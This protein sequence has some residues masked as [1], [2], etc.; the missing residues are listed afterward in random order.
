MDTITVGNWF[1]IPTDLSETKIHWYFNLTKP[2]YDLCVISSTIK[3]S[4]VKNRFCWRQKLRAV[5]SW[6]SIWALICV[7]NE[8]SIHELIA[9][10]NDNSITIPTE[11]MIPPIRDW[12]S[13]LTLMSSVDY[14]RFQAAKILWLFIFQQN[15]TQQLNNHI[16]QTQQMESLSAHVQFKRDI[17]FSFIFIFICRQ[18]RVIHR[19]FFGTLSKAAC[20]AP[21][22]WDWI[23]AFAVKR[24]N[25]RRKVLFSII[26]PAIWR[27]VEF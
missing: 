3:E 16:I 22:W 13:D 23:S 17:S 6:S 4:K 11:W 27:W 12:I 15:F 7:R 8:I 14:R 1:R 25:K 24:R 2:N 5:P 19:N 18:S 10:Y 21:S 26:L 20:S 9:H